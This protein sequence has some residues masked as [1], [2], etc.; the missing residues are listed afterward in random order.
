[1]S[2]GGF[3]GK[4][5]VAAAAGGHWIAHGC[6]SFTLFMSIGPPIWV[7]YDFEALFLCVFG[8]TAV[9]TFQMVFIYPG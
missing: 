5:A 4:F 6:S 8:H 7:P 1:M 9:F 3:L 2:S